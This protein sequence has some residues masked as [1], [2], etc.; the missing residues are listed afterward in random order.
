MEASPE[1]ANCL[2]V[3]N[4]GYCASLRWFDHQFIVAIPTP[5]ELLS[6]CSSTS[7]LFLERLSAGLLEEA[8]SASWQSGSARGSAQ[9]IWISLLSLEGLLLRSLSGRVLAE[10]AAVVFAVMAHERLLAA[11]EQPPGQSQLFLTAAA[12]LVRLSFGSQPS[13]RLLFVSNTT[14]Q[15]SS[16]FMELDIAACGSNHTFTSRWH[17]W[18]ARL[19]I[20]EHAMALVPA[21]SS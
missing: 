7:I 3:L 13:L 12:V 9:A 8:A 16:C 10:R 6:A 2:R 21:N 5:L 19:W 18:N 11:L 14:M 4:T 1:P 17:Y 20:L 15:I